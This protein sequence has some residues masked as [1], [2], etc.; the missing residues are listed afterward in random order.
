MIDKIYLSNYEICST[1]KIA[2]LLGLSYDA[3]NNIAYYGDNKYYGFRMREDGNSA[4]LMPVIN[5]SQAA[6]LFDM[7]TIGYLF[8]KKTENGIIFGYDSSDRPNLHIGFTKGYKLDDNTEVPIMFYRP[9]YNNSTI[10]ILMN[11]ETD[12]S[13]NE[14]NII[15][16][17]YAYLERIYDATGIS[18]DFLFVTKVFK[19]TCDVTEFTLN[20][21]T[22]V[23]TYALSDNAKRLVFKV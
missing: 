10:L 6:Y 21:E 20:G 5:G 3:E 16:D 4:Q 23:T 7:S 18:T 15:S 12:K 8:Y 14:N 22:Y 1:S 13:I 2:E 11:N 19:Q 17:S 9:V